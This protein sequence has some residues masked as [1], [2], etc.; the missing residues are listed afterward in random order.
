VTAGGH[1]D[2]SAGILLPLFSAHS[3]RSWG[4]GEFADLPVLAGWMRDAG[5]RVLQLL[6]LNELAPGQTSPYSG[7]SA[8]ALD[9]IFIA[10][11]EVPDF[12]AAG[13]EGGLDTAQRGLLAHVRA[14]PGVD[15]W[16][17]RTL[18]DRALRHAFRH[19][20]DHEWVRDTPRAEALRAFEHLEA[21]WLDDY[22]TFRALVHVSGGQDWRQ[23][24]A[25]A[26]DRQAPALARAAREHHLEVLYRK[27]LQWLA[28]TQWQSARRQA[29]GIRVFGDFPFM[30]AADSADAWSHQHLFSFDGT[31]G[32]PPDAFSE[33]GQNWKLPV[34]R[35]DVLARRQYDWFLQRARRMADLFDGFRVDHVVG[36]FR[37]WVF[38]LDGS[39]PHFTPPDEASQIAQGRAV[40][41]TIVSTGAEVI[42]EDLGTIPP[43][44]RAAIDELGIPGYKVIRWERLW[45]EPGRP[46]IDPRA[47]TTRSLAT[48][49]THDTETLAEW[50]QEA[51]LDDRRL[52]LALP[53]LADAVAALALT[54][55]SP[56]V[57]HVRDALLEALYASG[58]DLLTI[59]VQDL[60]GWTERVNVP[61]VVDDRNWTWKLPWLV[62]ALTAQPDAAA[63]AATLREWAR[64]HG[65]G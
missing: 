15:Y 41:E 56:F 26:R 19:F 64:R 60:F 62:D 14:R 42:A 50:W 20:V 32:A 61:A 59:P 8:M 43:F 44:V 25:E 9:P 47:F 65:R 7:L 13:G 27:Y 35:W 11:S 6:P 3:T 63:R 49:G 33:E 5:L 18:K 17:V 55:D 4:I 12:E 52:A 46:F 28:Q 36:L 57:P 2:R 22:A 48:S 10:L 21:W 39:R 34:Y 37:T 16:A 24:P 31:V 54:P 23:W 30:V 45:D 38:P 53:S 29:A 51:S 1:S 40:L 58:S